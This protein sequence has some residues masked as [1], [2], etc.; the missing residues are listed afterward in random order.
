MLVPRNGHTLGRHVSLKKTLV[1][2]TMTANVITVLT[3]HRVQAMYF[4]QTF[5]ALYPIIHSS[6]KWN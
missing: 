3:V 4:T 2:K 5:C 6:L 1:M